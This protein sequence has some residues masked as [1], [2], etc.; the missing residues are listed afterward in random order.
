MT[1]IFKGANLIFASNPDIN[2]ISKLTKK[3]K[4][5]KKLLNIDILQTNN[6]Q[7]EIEKEFENEEEED[8]YDYEDNNFNKIS[9]YL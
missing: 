4:K 2:T 1:S 8:E 3:F 7:E 5:N 9:D 6:E